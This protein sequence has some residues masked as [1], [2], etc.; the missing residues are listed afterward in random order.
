MKSA[1]SYPTQQQH[2]FTIA[3]YQSVIYVLF[4]FLYHR[5]RSLLIEAISVSRGYMAARA[6]RNQASSGPP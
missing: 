2:I 5:Q 3:L 4:P 6:R 1:R